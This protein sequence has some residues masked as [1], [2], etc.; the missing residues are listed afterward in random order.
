M[1]KK[2]RKSVFNPNYLAQQKDLGIIES[3]VVEVRFI[4]G[5]SNTWCVYSG[6]TNH[7]CNTLQ[8]FR[9]IKKLSDGKVTLH[10]GSKARVVVVSIKVVEL[11]FILN[12][13][14]ILYDCLFIHVIKK[15]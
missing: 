1:I 7:I 11:F 12:K 10:L 8:R 4:V 6:V 9:E 3:L 13:I 5:T 15:N 2:P 14:L